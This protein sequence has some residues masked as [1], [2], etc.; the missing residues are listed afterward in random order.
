MHLSR[1]TNECHCFSL[2]IYVLVGETWLLCKILGETLL[3]LEVVCFSK[4]RCSS[5][6]LPESVAKGSLK[7]TVA[8]LTTNPWLQRDDVTS[9]PPTPDHSKMIAEK[10]CWEELLREAAEKGCWE[11]LL[12]RAAEK[13]CW[14]EL[15]RKAAEKTCWEELL[16]PL[17]FENAAPL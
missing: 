7:R 2:K 5:L 13:S 9:W 8:Y 12:R 3:L 14:E 17:L 15:L 10:S 11:K 4:I 16:R 1:N 6:T